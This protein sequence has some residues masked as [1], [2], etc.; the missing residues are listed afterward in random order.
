MRCQC[1]VIDDVPVMGFYLN[2]LF[3][4]GAFVFFYEKI[5]SPGLQAQGL[6]LP[7]DIRIHMQQLCQQMRTPEALENA[8]QTLQRNELVPSIQRFDYY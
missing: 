4:G 1:G 8:S 2:K 5:Y 7:E 6:R 3:P